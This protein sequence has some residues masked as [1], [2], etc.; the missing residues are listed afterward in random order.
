M[1]CQSMTTVSLFCRQPQIVFRTPNA[2]EY[3]VPPSGSRSTESKRRNLEAKGAVHLQNMS[4]LNKKGRVFNP[5]SSA[6]N[7]FA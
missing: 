7:N 5:S 3:T 1:L 2:P 4:P 6:Q